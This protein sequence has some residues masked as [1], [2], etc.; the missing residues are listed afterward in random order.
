[1][2]KKVISLSVAFAF[3]T[4]SITGVLLYLKQKSHAIEITHVVFGLLFITMA[5]FHIYNNWASLKNY[6]KPRNETKF[7]KEIIY[8]FI[9]F[10]VILTLS[11][12]SILEPI[13]EFGRIFGKGEKEKHGISFSEK[14]SNEDKLGK[15][16]VLIV[17]KNEKAMF[18]DINIDVVDA[19]NNVIETLYKKDT[20]NPER[21][22]NLI[23][24][25]KIQTASPFTLRITLNDKGK[26]DEYVGEV[27]SLEAGIYEPI[28]IA[29]SKLERVIV[30]IKK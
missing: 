7:S 8:I 20:L 6:S 3:L 18:S 12:T 14:K 22:S 2:N 21:P 5:A 19:K 24:S 23:L 25:T 9:T 4:I 17:Q 26:K 13:A 1:M 10:A 30:E 16:I 27:K 15:E 28:E 29:N 11:L